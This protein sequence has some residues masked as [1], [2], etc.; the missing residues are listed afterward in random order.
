MKVPRPTYPRVNCLAPD[1]KRGT[2]RLATLASGA[3][4]EWICGP[5][6][7]AVPKVWRQRLSLYRRRYFAAERKGDKEGMAVAQ[8]VF[9]RRWDR[10][11]ALV[12]NPASVTTGE[13]LP[14]G[15]ADQLKRMGL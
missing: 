15:V 7:Q 2:T 4:P 1:C 8:R 10:I 11:A 5:H 12:R 3:A 13:G 14:L 9:W 6:W